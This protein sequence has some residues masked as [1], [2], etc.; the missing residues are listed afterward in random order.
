MILKKQKQSTEFYFRNLIALFAIIFSSTTAYGW[1]LG[2]FLVISNVTPFPITITIT[3]NNSQ[4]NVPITIP[5]SGLVLAPGQQYPSGGP[6][7]YI[8]S[9]YFTLGACSFTVKATYSLGT[10]SYTSS[11]TIQQSNGQYTGQLDGGNYIW[12]LQAIPSGGLTENTTGE[13][14]WR[15]RLA[16]TAQN[17]FSAWMSEDTAIQNATL[18]QI[19]IPGVHDAGMYMTPLCTFF[20]NAQNTQTQT[21]SSLADMVSSGA[22]FFDIRPT[23]FDESGTQYAGHCS[24][25]FNTPM[26]EIINCLPPDF[27]TSTTLANMI[28]N[29]LGANTDVS[30]GNQG[31]MGVTISSALSNIGSGFTGTNDVVILQF[32]HFMDI[33]QYNTGGSNFDSAE[34]VTL[35]TTIQSSLKNYLYPNNPNFLNTRINEIT[36]TGNKIIVLFDTSHFSTGVKNYILS[37]PGVYAIPPVLYDNYS[38]TNEYNVMR[39]DQFKKLSANAASKY[40]L[41][42]W[43]L[44]QSEKQIVA[45]AINTKGFIAAELLTGTKAIVDLAL[46]LPIPIL[47]LA[48]QANMRTNEIV[49]Y[50]VDKNVFPNIL[51]VDNFNYY[52]TCVAQ[53]L[54]YLRG[55]SSGTNVG[56]VLKNKS[57][58]STTVKNGAKSTKSTT[59]H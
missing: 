59:K 38:G 40:F 3:P 34:I 44:T 31:C 52:H 1:G 2:A 28:A 56:A 37:Q 46:G 7:Q 18:S 29:A 15:L 39:D 24:W 41:L 10:Q 25:T 6:G 36:A 23:I 54:N 4:W 49:D 51:Y 27:R 33:Y 16:F 30:L 58:R 9:D 26:Q 48:M 35:M 53:Q 12:N 32:S 19:T 42:S 14:Q 47:A 45:C 8:E 5:S 20:A 17:G 50:C 22:R 43:T 13:S 11:A 55:V 57:T 21:I